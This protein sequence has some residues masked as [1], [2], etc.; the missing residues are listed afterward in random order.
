[1]VGILL[2]R[3][4]AEGGLPVSQMTTLGWLIRERPRTT[5]QLAAAEKVR[6]QSMAQ[7]IREL[8]AG[9]LVE[10]RNDP[11]DRRQL[12]IRITPSGRARYDYLRRVERSSMAEAIDAS[13]MDRE[14]AV[15]REALTLLRRIAD[16]VA[17]SD[18]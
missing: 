17:D 14:Q 5:A 4:R 11:A 16:Y 18:E 3:F 10:R 13:L 1:M 2:R 6:H 15:L 7:T 8:E 12:L 9:G